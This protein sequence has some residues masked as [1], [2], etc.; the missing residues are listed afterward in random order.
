V[1]AGVLFKHGA[2]DF[3]SLA[4]DESATRHIGHAALL[5]LNAVRALDELT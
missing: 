5:A 2:Y 4:H 3:A 1:R